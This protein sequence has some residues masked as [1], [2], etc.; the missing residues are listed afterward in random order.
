MSDRHLLYNGILL[1]LEELLRDAKTP[2]DAIASR[3]NLAIVEMR[4]GRWGEAARDLEQLRLPEGPGVSGGTIAYLLGLC[5]E[6]LGRRGD[7][8]TSFT[9]AAKSD[10]MLSMRGPRTAALAQDKLQG[11]GGVR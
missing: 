6:A 10:S 2:V 4:L 8:T 11:T 3:L 7:A 5:Y 9:A 1:R